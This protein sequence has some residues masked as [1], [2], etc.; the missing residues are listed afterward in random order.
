MDQSIPTFIETTL[1]ETGDFIAEKFGKDGLL[2]TKAD[3]SDYVTKSDIEAQAFVVNAIQK[4]FPKHGIIAEEDEDSHKAA[5]EK[6]EFFW[7]LDP[8]DGTNNFATGI[9]LFGIMLALMQNEEI[10]ASGV[11]L[12]LL[13]QYYEAQE[14][15]GSFL[16]GNKIQATQKEHWS[17]SFGCTSASLSPTKQVMR[18]AIYEASTTEK[19]W[20]TAYGSAA[21][22]G[23]FVA[24]GKRD[25]YMTQGS[26]VWDYASIYLLLKEAGC[27]VTNF[28]GEDW[29]FTDREMLAAYPPLH[30]SLLELL[31]TD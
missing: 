26:N 30:K 13:K 7:I 29:K 27:R 28:K 1:K 11:Y 18:K 12:P 24:S 19:F 22:S 16:N 17:H 15:K 20:L 10:I 21:V 5:S 25:W 2:R 31:S 8:I 9:P 6:K 14:D 4:E 3:A 23:S